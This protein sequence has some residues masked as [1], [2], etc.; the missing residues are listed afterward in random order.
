MCNG[1]RDS[2]EGSTRRNVQPKP[3]PR[4]A[5]LDVLRGFTVLLMIFVDEI[6]DAYPH[7]NHSPW[8]NVTLA[9]F[10][11]PWFLFMVGTSLS[12]S[13]RKYTVAPE[14]DLQVQGGS[15]VGLRLRDKGTQVVCVRALKLLLLGILLQGARDKPLVRGA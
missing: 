9:D 5:S 6:G 8:N 2:T 1:R 3:S 15:S 11:M 10:V 7:L 12:L 4:L 13:L 14:T